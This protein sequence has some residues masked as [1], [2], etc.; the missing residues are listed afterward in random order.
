MVDVA[1]DDLLSFL[2]MVG[3]IADVAVV[4]I[5]LELGTDARPDDFYSKLTIDIRR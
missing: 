1:D 3:L 2:T 5:G 4:D